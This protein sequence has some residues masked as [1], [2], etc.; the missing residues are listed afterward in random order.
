MV[1]DEREKL[2]HYKFDLAGAKNGFYIVFSDLKD[3][4]FFKKNSNGEYDV[5]YH[6]Q[7]GLTGEDVQGLKKFQITIYVD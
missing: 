7:V 5:R 1:D 2:D 4:M 3:N 6:D